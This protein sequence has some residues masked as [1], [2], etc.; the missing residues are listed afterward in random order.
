MYASPEDWGKTVR[1]LIYPVVLIIYLHHDFQV[2]L[3]RAFVV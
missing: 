3:E 1:N 2:P